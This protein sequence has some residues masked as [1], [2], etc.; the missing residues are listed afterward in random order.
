MGRARWA[1]VAAA[2]AGSLAI[3]EPAAAQQDLNCDDF[4]SQA[5]AQ[6]ELE[7]DLSDPHGLDGPRG[8]G[9]AGVQN[10]AC[11]D[12]DYGP[13]GGGGS[14][15]TTAPPVG[16][17]PP[18]VASDVIVPPVCEPGLCTANPLAAPSGPSPRRLQQ[19]PRTGPED[20][21]VLWSL[22]GA[23]AFLLVGGYCITAAADLQ[24][25]RT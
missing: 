23:G 14:T 9:F 3:A 4:A 10:V 16:S 18:P 1:I 8:P 24:R 5:E 25:R 7:R 2:V 22:L 21:V 19:I 20:A 6:A 13:G 11:E 12:F 17:S 15:A